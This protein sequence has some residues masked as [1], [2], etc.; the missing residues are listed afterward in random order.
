MASNSLFNKSSLSN[1][2]TDSFKPIIL[3]CLASLA[4]VSGNKSQPVLDGTLYK[5]CGKSTSEAISE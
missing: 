3:F 4:T 1:E 2:E 5:I